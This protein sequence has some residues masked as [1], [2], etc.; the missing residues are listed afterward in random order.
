MGFMKIHF[1]KDRVQATYIVIWQ[2]KLRSDRG[3]RYGLAPSP[4][5][6][7]S[8]PLSHIETLSFDS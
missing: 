5:L 2:L 4:L 6:F 3:S 7:F 8:S 1:E